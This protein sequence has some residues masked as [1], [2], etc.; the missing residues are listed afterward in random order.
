MRSAEIRRSIDILDPLEATRMRALALALAAAIGSTTFTVCAVLPTPAAA[1]VEG[2]PTYEDFGLVWTR[3]PS[4]RDMARFYRTTRHDG[5]RG[6]AQVL[7]TATAEGRLDRSIL[8]EDPGHRQFGLAGVRVMERARVATR[9]GGT[10]EGRTFAFTLRF[11]NWP[12]SSLPDRF[13]PLDQHLMWEERPTLVGIW[14]MS[15]QD[16]GERIA[17]TVDCVAQSD[18]SLS[19]CSLV[20][21]DTP[22][23]GE[24]A[25]TSMGMAR[26][27][28]ADSSPLAGSTLRWTLAVERQSS[29]G[30]ASGG[31][32]RAGAYPA[33]GTGINAAVDVAAAAASGTAGAGQMAGGP[34]PIQGAQPGNVGGGM[35]G[36]QSAMVQVHGGR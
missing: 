3:N 25:L 15:G 7:C 16:R 2:Y 31:V 35:P 4:V 17:A 10:P 8:D 14:S 34:G 13:H 26:V 11:G 29:C 1:Q 5:R 33:L 12:P 9:D 32:G 27:E 18:G 28:R 36:C 20:S 6:L 21:A 19:N 24:A 23:F 22:D 30:A